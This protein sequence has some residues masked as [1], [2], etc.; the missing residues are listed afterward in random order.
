MNIYILI[1]LVLSAY[2]TGAIPTSVLVGKIF[3]GTD[4]R[5]HGSG[6]AGA[7]NTIRVLG[8]KAGV[9]VLIFDIFKGWL[10]V[11]LSVYSGFAS[12]SSQLVHFELILGIAAVLGHIFPVYVNFKGGKGVATVGGVMLSICLLPTLSALG[13]FI[14]VYVLFRYVSLGSMTAGLSFPVFVIFVYQTPFLSIRIV[15]ILV[16]LM[17][18]ITHRKNIK[19]LMQGEESKLKLMSKPKNPGY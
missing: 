7:T 6:N 5:E 9:P 19:R 16:A 13:V 10:A 18:I 8:P 2:L 15:S 17:L 14:L 11:E 12:G 4:V 1:L 3:Y